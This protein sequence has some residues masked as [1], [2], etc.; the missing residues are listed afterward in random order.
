MLEARE[1]TLI[2]VLVRILASILLGGVIGLDRGIK[3][4]PAGLRTY[5]LVSLGACVVMLIN[6]YTY[7]LYGGG[8]PVRMGAQVVSGIGFLGAGTIIVTTHNQIKGLTT[9]AGLWASACVGLAMGI[10]FYEAAVLGG[11]G[12]FFIL[13]VLHQ[14]DFMIRSR[15]HSINVYLELDSAIP[16]GSFIRSARDYDL[17]VS[18]VQKE[19]DTG[20]GEHMWAMIITVRGKQKMRQEEL[21]RTLKRFE[22][23]RYI[24]VL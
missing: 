23:V 13:T 21:V 2:G 15:T 7:Q 10:G 12:V 1:L 11:F 8:D 9:A 17:E 3:H 19:S 24:E 22:G 14:W 18:N 16:L 5:M 20:L 6:Q 4:R